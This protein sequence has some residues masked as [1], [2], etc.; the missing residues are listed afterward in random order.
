MQTISFQVHGWGSGTWERKWSD[1]GLNYSS[2]KSQTSIPVV[3]LHSLRQQQQQASFT[4]LFTHTHTHYFID[5]LCQNKGNKLEVSTTAWRAV[6]LVD[7]MCGFGLA[8]PLKHSPC[9]IMLY[10]MA[11]KNGMKINSQA[12]SF[13]LIIVNSCYNK[14]GNVHRASQTNA[15]ARCFHFHH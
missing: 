1:I 7:R 14:L 12:N 2:Q 11:C 3:G 9:F 5:F 6:L 10:C 13:G 8:F 4:F 15:P